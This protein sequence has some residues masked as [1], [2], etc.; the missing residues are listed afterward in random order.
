MLPDKSMLFF[1]WAI[2]FFGCSEEKDLLEE[3]VRIEGI[4]LIPIL[5]IN[6]WFTVRNNFL[7]SAGY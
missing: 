7:C 5:E 2:F 3:L 6:P 4:A 1:L